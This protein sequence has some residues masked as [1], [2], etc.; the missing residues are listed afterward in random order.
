[1]H[2]MIQTEGRLFVVE[3]F[4]V[5]YARLL[6]EEYAAANIHMHFLEGTFKKAIFFF[7][8]SQGAQSLGTAPR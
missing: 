3:H 7:Q 2:G 4:C 6:N 5:R 1:M 8:F